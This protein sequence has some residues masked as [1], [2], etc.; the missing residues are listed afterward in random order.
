VKQKHTKYTQINTNESTHSEKPN[1][2]NYKN[3]SCKCAYDCAV[4]V[5]N[6]TRN[7]SDNLPS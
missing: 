4:S 3:C 5:H 1:P 6:T 7:S 2:E